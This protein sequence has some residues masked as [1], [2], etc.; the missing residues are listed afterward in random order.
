MPALRFTERLFLPESPPLGPWLSLADVDPSRRAQLLAVL[1]LTEPAFALT[2]ARLD[3]VT[4]AELPYPLRSLA[5]CPIECW[6]ITEAG[7]LLYRM[8]IHGD[9]ACFFV[10]DTT[11]RVPDAI[12][13]SYDFHGEGSDDATPGSL[14]VRLE[15][16]QARACAETRGTELRTISFVSRPRV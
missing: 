9:G 10:R 5:E 14:A 4:T 12:V 15:A 6:D 16:A 3:T 1:Q 11:Q 13:S 8:W 7:A 2:D